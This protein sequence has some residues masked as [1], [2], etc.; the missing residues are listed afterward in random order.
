LVPAFDGG[1]D[2]VWIGGPG[3]GFG[4]FVGFRDEAVDGGLEVDEGVEDTALEAPLGE[5]GEETLDS[6]EPRARCRREVKGEA[7]MAVRM[8]PV[9]PTLRIF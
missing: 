1:D 2:L 3:E 5:F 9:C 4:V 7:F 8:R 6:I